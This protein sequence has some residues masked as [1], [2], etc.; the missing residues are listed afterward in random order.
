[1]PTV[2]NANRQVSVVLTETGANAMNA[3]YAEYGLARRW[4]AGDV[5]K[6]QLW[7][8]MQTLGSAFVMGGEPPVKDCEITLED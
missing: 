4:S 1:M 8:V 5:L 7:S 3:I 6:D 2:I